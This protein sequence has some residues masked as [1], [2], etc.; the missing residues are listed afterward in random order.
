MFKP[1][2][3]RG[4]GAPHGGQQ[5]RAD[6]PGEAWRDVLDCFAFGLVEHSPHV[7][8]FLI[9]QDARARTLLGLDR[10]HSARDR[11]LEGVVAAIHGIKV[12]QLGYERQH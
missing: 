3:A 8:D 1:R 7:A 2:R 4:L 6:Q 10:A 9:A 11:I 5:Q 12:E